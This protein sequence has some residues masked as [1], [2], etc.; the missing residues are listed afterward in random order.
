MG[1]VLCSGVGGRA[2]RSQHRRID[3][4]WWFPGMRAMV[5]AFGGAG[6][7]VTDEAELGPALDAAMAFNG[8]AIV[9]VKISAMANRKPQQFNWHG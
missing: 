9:N 5:S 4:R 1:V 6:F 2:G 8:P 7:Y 3:D